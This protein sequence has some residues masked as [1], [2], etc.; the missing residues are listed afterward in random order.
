MIFTLPA[1]S[2]PSEL[3][4]LHPEAIYYDLADYIRYKAGR[5]TEALEAES[6]ESYLLIEEEA[7]RD[8][9]VMAEITGIPRIVRLCPDTLDNPECARLVRL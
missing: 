2:D 6:H 9:V 7:L 3:C 5:S 8:L 1:G 4:A